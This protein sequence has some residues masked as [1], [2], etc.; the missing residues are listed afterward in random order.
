MN[1]IWIL[2]IDDDGW[3]SVLAVL[4][5]G[6]PVFPQAKEGQWTL[7]Q[8]SGGPAGWVHRSL[9]GDRLKPGQFG[10]ASPLP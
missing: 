6:T 1:K 7:V 2:R 4:D 10:P 9:I 3:R 5:L 8:V